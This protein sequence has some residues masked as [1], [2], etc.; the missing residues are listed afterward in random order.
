MKRRRRNRRRI[1]IQEAGDGK[2]RMIAL[3]GQEKW[4]KS[5]EPSLATL[6]V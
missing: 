1:L 4:K 3:N 5:P 2:Q 6:F